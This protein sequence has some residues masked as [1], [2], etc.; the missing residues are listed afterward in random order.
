MKNWFKKLGCLVFVLMATSSIPRV[1]AQNTPIEASCRN[2][3]QA[4]YSWYNVPAAKAGQERSPESAIKEKGSAFDPELLRRLNDDFAAQ[5]KVQGELVGLDFD[6]FLATNAE[7]HKHYVVGKIHPKAGA[8][9][10]EVFGIDSGKKTAKP[11]VEPELRYKDKHWQ[12]V[13]FHYEISKFPENENLLSILKALRE[14][15]EKP[16]K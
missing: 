12:F 11:V 8:Y 15:R 6:P 9:W 7:P 13:N 5:A 10:V 16:A 3:V 1:E 2:F 14:E 4:F